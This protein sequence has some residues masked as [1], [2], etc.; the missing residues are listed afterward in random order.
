MNKW[1]NIKKKKPLPDTEVLVRVDGHRGPSYCNV[2]CMVA[3]MWEDGEF[4]YCIEIRGEVVP[5]TVT[6]WMPLPKYR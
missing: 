2:F 5:G 4:H 1:I 3:F 6:H